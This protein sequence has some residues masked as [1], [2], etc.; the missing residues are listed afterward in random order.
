MF[1]VLVEELICCFATGSWVFKKIFGSG[2][3]C[4]QYEELPELVGQDTVLTAGNEVTQLCNVLQL[5]S[6]HR[7]A[8]FFLISFLFPVSHHS[9]LGQLDLGCFGMSERRELVVIS[10]KALQQGMYGVPLPSPLSFKLWNFKLSDFV[11]N[12]N[13]QGHN[14]RSWSR[15]DLSRKKTEFQS[16]PK[17]TASA[18]SLRTS[19]G[20]VFIKNCGRRAG[21]GGA[22]S[23]KGEGWGTAL[24]LGLYLQ[25]SFTAELP[26]E[27]KQPPALGLCWDLDLVYLK[28]A[29]SWCMIETGDF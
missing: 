22:A 6:L 10:S 18:S 7:T 27:L 20:F 17:I 23:L 1:C 16:E 24:S 8:Y 3:P 29:R 21:Q 13:G 14:V 5:S 2:M 9:W 11:I 28:D 26:S 4:H 15:F 25:M 12:C 19:W